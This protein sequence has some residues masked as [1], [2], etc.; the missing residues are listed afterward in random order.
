MAEAVV[1]LLVRKL[2]EALLN[3]AASYG[4]SLLCHEVSTIKG[5]YGQ[6]RKAHHQTLNYCQASRIS[7]PG[8]KRLSSRTRIMSCHKGTEMSLEVVLF[9]S[10][11]R[12]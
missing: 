12:L 1:G 8:F 3:E 4:L 2:G 7:L 9:M 5:L 10:I 11:I 6:I